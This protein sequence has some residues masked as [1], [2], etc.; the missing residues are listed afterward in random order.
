MHYIKIIQS[1]K[2]LTTATSSLPE[3]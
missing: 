2:P 1:R 3:W